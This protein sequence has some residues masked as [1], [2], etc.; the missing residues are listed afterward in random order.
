MAIDKK[1]IG[2]GQMYIVDDINDTFDNIVNVVDN[3]N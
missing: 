1:V 2:Q 3:G